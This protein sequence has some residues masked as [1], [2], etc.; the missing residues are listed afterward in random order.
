MGTFREVV[1]LF[2]RLS[3]LGCFE[4]RDFLPFLSPM[5]PSHPLVFISSELVISITGLGRDSFPPLL[6]FLDNDADLLRGPCLSET[7]TFR[8][9]LDSN[10][11]SSEEA[12]DRLSLLFGDF[13]L[14]FR[15]LEPQGSLSESC[16][17]TSPV[18]DGLPGSCLLLTRS[19]ALRLVDILPAVLLARCSSSEL[20]S[21]EFNDDDDDC[22]SRSIEMVLVDLG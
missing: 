15:G 14:F 3:C 9:L 17:P 19:G 11:S 12:N 1:L 16:M 18:D 7:T 22:K 5:G 6:F 10:T 20:S 8:A 2:F 21:F 13:F 4:C